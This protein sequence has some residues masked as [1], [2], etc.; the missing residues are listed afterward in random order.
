MGIVTFNRH[1]VK[2]NWDMWKLKT[3]LDN[4]AT[5]GLARRLAQAA[6]AESGGLEAILDSYIQRDGN[7]RGSLA[8]RVILPRLLPMLFEAL[9]LPADQ[10]R[11]ALASVPVKRTLS[12]C[13]LTLDKYGLVFPQRFYAPLM[14]VWNLTYVCNLRCQHCYENAGALRDRGLTVEEL[15]L[16]R[17]L[18]IVDEIAQSHIP[19]LSLSGGE[20]LMHPDFWPV[21]ERAQQ[22]GIY[23]SINTNG[24]LITKDIARRL[25]DCGLGYA[26]ISLDAPDAETHD[27]FR[28]VAGSW[29]RTV[30]GIKNLS[31]T[32]VETL[33]S[34]TITRLN[35]KMLPQLLQMAGSLGVS[36]VMAY[37]FIPTGRAVGIV[38]QDLTP[39][40]REE[41]LEILYQYAAGGGAVCGTAPQLGRVCKQ[42]SRP[43]LIPLAHASA[44][45]IKNLEVIAEIVGGCG[46][47]RA[48]CALQPDGRI[49]PCV[50]MPNVTIGYIDRDPLLDV[51]HRS[52]L[53]E[54]LADR[55]DLKGHCGVCEYRAV[56]GGCRARAFAYFGDFKGPDPGCINNRQYARRL[57]ADI[58]ARA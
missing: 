40:M 37:N 42:H 22:R 54:M 21:L 38:D 46:V 17:K 27:R 53:L 5:R 1:R 24:T 47:G 16:G 51:W 41:C 15:P 58:A 12:N 23:V 2:Q 4:F 35:Y 25:E 10:A 55:S 29:Q 14:V 20:P 3:T 9:D 56:C 33:L 39:E 13:L 8:L 6:Q 18:D 11:Q 44:N 36:K 7:P 57:E 28:G 26:G 49:T 30:E 52:E 34:V 31:A 48:Y 45:R 50:Y 19:T 43:D 32:K